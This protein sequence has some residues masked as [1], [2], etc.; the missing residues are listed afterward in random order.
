LFTVTLPPPSASFDSVLVT[1]MDITER[2]RAEYLA[3]AVFEISPDGVYIVGRD[4][5]Y[6]RVNPA[7]ER[8]WRLP[9]DKIVG[10]RL[11]ELAGTQPFEET[12]KPAM[13]RCVA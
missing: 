12:Y 6:Q 4:Y 5:R 8:R 11:D 3:A 7:F 10:M 9:A 13:D 2:K 1:V